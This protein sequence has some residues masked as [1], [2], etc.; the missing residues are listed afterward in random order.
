MSKK[1]LQGLVFAGMGFTLS[2]TEGY[3][4]YCDKEC[5]KSMTACERSCQNNNENEE[6]LENCYHVCEGTF[7]SCIKGCIKHEK[8]L[9]YPKS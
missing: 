3:A 8:G 7:Q 5:L 6:K 1:F 2:A 9:E 4:N